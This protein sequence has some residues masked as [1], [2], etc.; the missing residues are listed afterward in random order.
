MTGSQPVFYRSLKAVEE[1][2]L[3]TTDLFSLISITSKIIKHVIVSSMWQHI[4]NYNLINNNQHGFRKRFSTTTQLLDVIHQATK[5]LA[6]QQTYHLVSFD[7]AKAF[8][9]V[10]HHFLIHK[11]KFY[12]F[13]EKVVNWIEIWL[14][15]R[16]ARVE[17]NN[18]RSQT[19][20][21]TQGSPQPG[22]KGE[23]PF[24]F[25]STPPPPR[26]Y[27]VKEIA[28]LVSKYVSTP[29]YFKLNRI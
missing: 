1:T 18:T 10:P 11:I 7:F 9:K 27:L 2:Y 22:V 14:S 23:P 20:K 24:L 13:D 12:K 16:N 28:V 26:L 19:F 25:K 3:I 6:K 4:D 8:N 21:I 5:F 29:Y 17:V 15:D